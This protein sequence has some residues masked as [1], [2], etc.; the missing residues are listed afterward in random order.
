MWNLYKSTTS[1]IIIKNISAE[2]HYSLLFVIIFYPPVFDHPI[3]LLY[4]T[5]DLKSKVC[6]L[7]LFKID[8]MV[9]LL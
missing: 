1:H 5:P 4:D 3:A 7:L 6:V 2:F 8:T 9:L